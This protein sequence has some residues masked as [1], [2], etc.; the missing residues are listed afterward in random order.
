M[1]ATQIGLRFVRAPTFRAVI[2][3]A[4]GRFHP[5]AQDPNEQPAMGE[6]EMPGLIGARRPT[7]GGVKA[8]A[9]RAERRTR[10]GVHPIEARPQPPICPGFIVLSP[11][12]LE[13]HAQRAVGLGVP[14]VETE[15]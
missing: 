11:F 14:V 7:G 4:T 6:R 5:L 1:A 13:G 12:R 9:R 3:V 10:S 15:G 2:G 8:M